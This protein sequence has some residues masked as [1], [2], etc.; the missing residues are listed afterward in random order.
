MTKDTEEF[1]K[2]TDAVAGREY[3]LPRD[4]V[5][6]EQKRLDQREHQNWVRIE[7]CNLLPAR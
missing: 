3:T 7:S 5:A 6:S 1:S 4:E 2:F